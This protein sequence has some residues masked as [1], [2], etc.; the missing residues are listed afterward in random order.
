M[1]FVLWISL[2]F[3]YGIHPKTYST[4]LLFK[5]STFTII[6]ITLIFVVG[7]NAFVVGMANFVV[8]MITFVVGMITSNLN[9][10]TEKWTSFFYRLSLSIF[11]NTSNSEINRN[12]SILL[13]WNIFHGFI[14]FIIYLFVFRIILI[15]IQ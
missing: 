10:F 1:R 11:N 2:Y 13:Y 4:W 7:M 5:N 6:M 9:S 12:I 8:G 14:I 15:L 3:I